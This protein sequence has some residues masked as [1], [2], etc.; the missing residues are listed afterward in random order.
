MTWGIFKYNAFD[1]GAASFLTGVA[2]DSCQ[3][4]TAW[5]STIPPLLPPP[6]NASFIQCFCAPTLCEFIVSTEHKYNS[7]GACSGLDR[8]LGPQFL[9]LEKWVGLALNVDAEIP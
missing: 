3:A 7:L 4:H 8:P 2:H 9:Y 1:S 6:S 5:E